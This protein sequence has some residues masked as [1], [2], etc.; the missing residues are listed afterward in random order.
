MGA[1]HSRFFEASPE[2]PLC[3]HDGGS[4]CQG[5]AKL[6]FRS[7][8]MKYPPLIQGRTASTGCPEVSPMGPAS[9]HPALCSSSPGSL[10]T[11]IA[12]KHHPEE[13]GIFAFG[14][15]IKDWTG[16][17]FCFL[18]LLKFLRL[19]QSWKH[20]ITNLEDL[21]AFQM[22]FFFFFFTKIWRQELT[23]G[24]IMTCSEQ[25][26]VILK[27]KCCGLGENACSTSWSLICKVPI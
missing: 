22:R 19:F 10:P 24:L 18:K 25:H 1:M 17:K 12:R 5:A 13:L 11:E 3:S 4:R 15:S 8:I 9:P 26:D 23:P 6:L 20:R 14:D 16:V 2:L 21:R 7:C 27:N